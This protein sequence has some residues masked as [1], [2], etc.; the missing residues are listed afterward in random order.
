M[1]GIATGSTGPS[2][3][4]ARK[5]PSFEIDREDTKAWLAM[6]KEHEIRPTRWVDHQ[7]LQNMGLTTDFEWLADRA[8]LTDFVKIRAPTYEKLTLECL[9]SFHSNIYDTDEAH[10]C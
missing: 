5:E 7:L 2:N 6:L 10:Y 1:K 9:S 4:R 3:K 8:R